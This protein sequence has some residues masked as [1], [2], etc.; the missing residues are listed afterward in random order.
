MSIYLN[1]FRLFIQLI[2]LFLCCCSCL[3][4]Y[5]LPRLVASLTFGFR[6][7]FSGI[8]IS[9]G[10]GI[11]QLSASPL[12]FFANYYSFVRR[13]YE[14]IYL[15]TQPETVLLINSLGTC[16]QLIKMNESRSPKKN[17]QTETD[18]FRLI[19]VLSPVSLECRRVDRWG[20]AYKRLSLKSEF[21]FPK[22]QLMCFSK[23]EAWDILNWQRRFRKYNRKT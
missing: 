10:I 22:L 16:W 17:P 9:I 2:S 23:L 3:L 19:C 13:I 11:H 12:K 6:K 8:S 1:K 5:W 14:Y 20:W 4:A 7:S 21:A 18:V 15:Y